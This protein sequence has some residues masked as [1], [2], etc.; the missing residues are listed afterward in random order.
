MAI[1]HFLN[2]GHG[3]CSIIQ[4]DSGNVT[5]IDMCKGNLSSDEETGQKASQLL[6]QAFETPKIVGMEDCPT[7]PIHYCRDMLGLNSIFRFVLTHPDMDHMDGLAN[8]MTTLQVDNFWEPGIRRPTINE[9]KAGFQKNDWDQYERLIN[10]KVP[11]TTV[12]SRLEGSKFKYANEGGDTGSGDSL[13]ILSPDQN[14]IKQANELE[15]CNDA[16]YVILYKTAHGGII[17][18]GDSH[19]KTWELILKKHSDEVKDCAVLIAPHHGRDSDRSFD[20]LKVLKPRLTLFGCA[21]KEHLAHDAWQRLGLPVITN[22]QAGNIILDVN[23]YGIN[24]FVENES[25][26]K[27]IKTSDT[28]CKLYESFFIGNLKPHQPTQPVLI[29]K[30]PTLFPAQ[31]PSK[32]R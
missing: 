20:F 28:S 8:L 26:A 24:I 29:A 14:L 32:F 17:F 25:F 18:A 11:G 15:E 23:R 21:P 3:D 9:F 31:L 22:N 4:H 2:V 30:R 19:D 7:N 1:V 12:L 5:M 13:F 16:S 6:S 10:K 27:A